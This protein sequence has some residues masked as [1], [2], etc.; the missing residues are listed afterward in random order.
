M[1]K[2][3]NNKKITQSQLA[4]A[5]SIPLSVINDYEQGKGVRNGYYISLIKKYLNI[6][7]NTI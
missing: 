6:D 2:A 3:R 5:I 7:K 4:K 1:Q